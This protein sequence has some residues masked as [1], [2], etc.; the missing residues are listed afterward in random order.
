MERLKAL[1]Y[2]VDEGMV[3]DPAGNQIFILG[4]AK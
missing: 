1:G 3:K 4:S 2:S